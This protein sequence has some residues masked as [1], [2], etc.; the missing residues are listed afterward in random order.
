MKWIYFKFL[1]FNPNKKIDVNKALAH[2]YVKEF[3]NQYA[4]NEIIYDNPIIILQMIMLNILLKNIGK[5]YM[6]KTQRKK[7]RKKMMEK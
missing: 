3:H 4:D 7:L 2:N 6:M 5:D 1:E